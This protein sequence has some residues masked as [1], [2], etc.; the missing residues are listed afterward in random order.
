M[1]T[2]EE[3]LDQI[4]K[5]QRKLINKT[6]DL[7]IKDD[8]I[9]EL[10]KQLREARFEVRELEIGTHT[11]RTLALEGDEENFDPRATGTFNKNIWSKA[12]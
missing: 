1:K 6:V 8:R 3:L 5:L 9:V 7:N 2:R 12:R 4:D 10:E 11:V